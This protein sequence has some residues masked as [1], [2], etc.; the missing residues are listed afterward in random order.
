MI[1]YVCGESNLHVFLQ[2]RALY[3]KCNGGVASCNTA[4]LVRVDNDVLLIDRAGAQAKATKVPLTL[5]LFQSGQL[6]PGFTFRRIA[7]GLKYEVRPM[8]HQDT[9]H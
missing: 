3:R 2:I 1:L 9:F 5:R 7:G 4:V 8:R 6:T